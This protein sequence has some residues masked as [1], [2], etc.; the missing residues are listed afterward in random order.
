MKVN[1]IRVGFD[2]RFIDHP[3]IGRYVSN[4]LQSLPDS[5]DVVAVC[6]PDGRTNVADTRP[7]AEVT[8][9]EAEPFGFREQLSL[10]RLLNSQ[11]IDC[12]HASQFTVPIAW[13]GPLVTTIHDC[14]YDRFPSEYGGRGWLARRYLRTMMR[15][16]VARS[17]RILTPSDS[18]RRD[19]QW[20]YGG[21]DEQFTTIHHGVDTE[22]F[23]P[24][25][26][27]PT[28]VEGEYLLYVGSARP[29]KNITGLLDGFALAV[30][31][32]NSPPTLVIVGDYNE[33]FI[34]LTEAVANREL[35]A[36]VICPGYVDE[37][38]LVSLYANAFG[39]V[40]PSHYEGFGFPVLE[41]M[42]SA[43]PIVVSDAA[44]LP[45]VCGDA[46]RYVEP[47]DIENIAAGI[48]DIVTDVTLRERLSHQGRDR[49]KEFTWERTAQST[50]E[51]YNEVR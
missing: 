43:T 7:A 16:A 8:V 42:A 25:A 34:D 23:N 12:F 4:L 31:Q 49:A 50:K 9:T 33:R 20:F 26:A 47:T 30:D 46:G 22:R 10:P 3:G 14:A 37:Q 29:R 2:A 35:Q 11:N 13:Q 40:F 45:E 5:V 17:D 36:N 44:S 19:V 18:T 15:L 24:D 27:A 21:A 32:L 6:T 28:I 51:V 41:A 39:F 48:T 38:E 1:K